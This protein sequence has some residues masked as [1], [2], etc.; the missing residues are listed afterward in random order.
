MRRSLLICIL[1]FLVMLPGTAP[2]AAA[3][4]GH[5]KDESQDLVQSS[6]ATFGSF[7]TDREFTWF[8][9]NL[10]KAK[11]LLIFPK[12]IKA[13]FFWGGSGGNGVLVVRDERTGEWSQPAFYSIGSVSLGLQIGAEDAEVIMFGMSRKAIDS[14]YASSFKFGAETSVAAGPR[15]LGA[16]KVLTAD[17]LSFAKARGLYAG[18]DLEGSGIMVRDDLNRAYYGKELRPI[19]IILERTVSNEHSRTLL[20]ALKKAGK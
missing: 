15:G 6:A 16:K 8:H 20:D 2:P 3:D 17:F 9:E 7:M 11:A 1:A 13:G 4:T 19:Q 10:S 5:L 12:I 18:L 14:L